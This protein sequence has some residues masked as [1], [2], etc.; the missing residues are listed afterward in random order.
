MKKTKKIINIDDYIRRA[1]PFLTPR[2]AVV[3]QLRYLEGKNYDEIAE[4]LNIYN[5]TARKLMCRAK[6]TIRQAI[7]DGLEPEQIID[8]TK[9]PVPAIIKDIKRINKVKLRVQKGIL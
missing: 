9:K 8:K 3:M 4:T 1:I 7:K 6:K 5:D 2:Q